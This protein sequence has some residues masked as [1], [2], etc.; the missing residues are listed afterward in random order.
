M[1]QRRR[2]RIVV[3]QGIDFSPMLA[4]AERLGAAAIAVEAE[5]EERRRLAARISE[6]KRQL[7][8]AIAGRQNDITVAHV[9]AALAACPARCRSLG[10][11]ELTGLAGRLE[12]AAKLLI[13]HDEPVG[14]RMISSDR[15]GEFVRPYTAEKGEDSVCRPRAS[16][17]SPRRR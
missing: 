6:L 5:L 13:D 1:I 15:T 3:L 4:A 7:R 11:R 2:G 14:S 12:A 17:M 8:N 16:A 9:A 10:L